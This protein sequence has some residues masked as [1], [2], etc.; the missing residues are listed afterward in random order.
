M[1]KN[2]SK[3]FAKLIAKLDLVYDRKPSPEK[4]EIYFDILK[5]Y[6]FKKIE[7]AVNKIL[8]NRVNQYYPKP[9]E[10]IECM[11]DNDGWY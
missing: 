6:D 10:I 11:R 9:S 7:Y 2:D 8:K 5:E 3:N 4:I 1:T